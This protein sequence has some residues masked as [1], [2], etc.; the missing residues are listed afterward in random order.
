MS[1]QAFFSRQIHAQPQAGRPGQLGNGHAA[2]LEASPPVDFQ[3][4]GICG[5]FRGLLPTPGFWYFLRID[6]PKGI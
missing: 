6:I 2:F 4:P 1:K 3:G 5:M